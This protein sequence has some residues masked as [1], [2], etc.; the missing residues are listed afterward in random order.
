MDVKAWVEHALVWQGTEEWLAAYA[1]RRFSEK[2]F[3]AMLR[4]YLL[5]ARKHEEYANLI[6]YWI[7]ANNITI[8]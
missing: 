3:Y 5:M 2:F 8:L 7:N 1:W 4:L 6:S